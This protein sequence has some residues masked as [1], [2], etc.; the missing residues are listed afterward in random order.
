G[1]FIQTYNTDEKYNRKA[2]AYRIFAN[3]LNDK[4][5][6]FTSTQRSPSA[7]EPEVG[8]MRR[9]NFR[10]YFGQFAWQPRPNQEGWLGWIRQFSFSP[11]QITYVQYDDT[12][13]LQSFEYE[14]RFLGLETRSGESLQ[15]SHSLV[16]EG[17]IEDFEISDGVL[18]IADTYWWQ[19]WQAEV[20][21]FAGRTLS[22]ESSISWGE[23]YNGNSFQTR[24]QLLWRANRHLNLNLRY[25]NNKIE[26]PEGMLTTNLLGSRLEY[27][28]T[29][30]IFG[31]LLGQWNS[32]QEEL[33]FNFRLQVIPKI[34]TDF[35]LIVNQIYNTE[36]KMLEPE[37][38]TIL[39]KLIWRFTI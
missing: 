34:G 5:S 38:G 10:E 29:P 4:I 36:A 19:Q 2:Y 14:I 11:A 12:G 16:G 3:Y 6:V 39:G 15:L 22:L 23:F 28:V 24:N 32:A 17:L 37:R 1:A 21:T 26:L 25:E 31:S 35:F 33:N 18:I 20:A 7:F 30:D 13:N 27:A 8:L 9:R